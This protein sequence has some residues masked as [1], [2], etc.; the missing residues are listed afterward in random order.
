MPYLKATHE[1]GL[2]YDSL[3]LFL[4]QLEVNPSLLSSRSFTVELR[5]LLHY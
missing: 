5:H 4:P 2:L 1:M 3:I